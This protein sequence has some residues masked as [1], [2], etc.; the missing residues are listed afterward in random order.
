[1]DQKNTAFLLCQEWWS[2]HYDKYFNIRLIKARQSWRYFGRVHEWM[3]NTKYESDDE[4]I[5]AGEAVV[6]IEENIV[7]FQ[8][9]TQDDDKTAKR[10]HRDKELL[11][12][13]HNENPIDCS[14]G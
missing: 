7:L 8:D 4:A 6:K 12:D 14:H 9:R 5:K 1:M 3:K 11:L 13:D 2:G 10:F